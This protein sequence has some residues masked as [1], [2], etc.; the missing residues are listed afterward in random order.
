MQIK[1]PECGDLSD[2]PG[3][4]T[5]CGS[6]IPKEYAERYTKNLADIAEILDAVKK[7]EKMSGSWNLSEAE[8]LFG[9]IK[10]LRS[11]LEPWAL[12]EVKDALV[13]ADNAY[14]SFRKVEKA[15]KAEEEERRRKEAEEAERKRQEEEKR[16]QKEAEEKERERKKIEKQKRKEAAAPERRRKILRRTIFCIIL[17]V[18]AYMAR[19]KILFAIADLTYAWEERQVLVREEK[20]L[21]ETAAKQAEELRPQLEE[22]LGKLNIALEGI[23]HNGWVTGSLTGSFTGAINSGLVKNKAARLYTVVNDSENADLLVRCTAALQPGLFGPRFDITLSVTDRTT[24][25]VLGSFWTKTKEKNL[26]TKIEK[27]VQNM[28]IAIPRTGGDR[29]GYYTGRKN[30]PVQK[31]AILPLPVQRAAFAGEEAGLGEEAETGAEEEDAEEEPAF[32]TDMALLQDALISGLLKNRQ[33]GSYM[34][35]ESA[36]TPD[37]VIETIVQELSAS[38]YRISV[39]VFDPLTMTVTGADSFRTGK[40]SMLKNMEREMRRIALSFFTSEKRRRGI[41]REDDYGVEYKPRIGISPGEGTDKNLVIPIRA[42]LYKGLLTNK[43]SSRYQVDYDGGNEN[44]TLETT[45]VTGKSPYMVTLTVMNTEMGWTMNAVSLKVSNGN[46][47]AKFV[48]AVKKLE[49]D[50]DMIL[51][52]SGDGE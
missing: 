46:M 30:I 15:L 42:A 50:F 24:S 23:R 4:C 7:I 44:Y 36:G 17:A 13:A 16:K 29:L 2:D 5:V 38:E 18:A 1:C 25:A 51:E 49:L 48:K 33:A 47:V 21:E 39:Y 11:G 43:F 26:F 12:K 8:K 45:A 27:G 34:V 6:T 37:M 35:L 9:R 40:K 31:F 19:D 10:S 20:E 41:V 28:V 32:D 22:P 14:S 52:N 3:L